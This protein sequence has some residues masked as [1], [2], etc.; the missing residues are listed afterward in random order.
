MTQAGFK[1]ID[2]KLQFRK[3]KKASVE[4]VADGL[5]SD[6]ENLISRLLNS[7]KSFD[8]CSY[9]FLE[10][11]YVSKIEKDMHLFLFCE[12]K[13]IS[14]FQFRYDNTLLNLKSV[15]IRYDTVQ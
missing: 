11:R 1:G 9:L 4:V 7:L 2:Q 5:H 15:C 6:P 14:D 10:R 12:L 13:S 3:F 8:V